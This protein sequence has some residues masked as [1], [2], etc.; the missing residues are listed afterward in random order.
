LVNP[1]RAMACAPFAADRPK[2]GRG[3]G[4]ARSR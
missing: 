3:E 4:P 2:K 1:L